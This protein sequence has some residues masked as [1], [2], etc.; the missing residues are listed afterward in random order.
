VWE[1]LSVKM[2]QRIILSPQK[3]TLNLFSSLRQ[4]SFNY[5]LSNTIQMEAVEGI[6]TLI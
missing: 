3:L 2:I 4:N 6:T 5:E 1:E